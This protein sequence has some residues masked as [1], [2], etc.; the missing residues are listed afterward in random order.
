MFIL[1][2]VSRMLS[3]K[4]QTKKIQAAASEVNFRRA[5][6]SLLTMIAGG[7][8]LALDYYCFVKKWENRKFVMIIKRNRIG[9][10]QKSTY[11]GAASINDVTHLGRWG[12]LPKGVVTP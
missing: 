2:L 3:S 10:P 7:S 12:N 5:V 9:P 6:F 4:N 8:T 1:L 11:V